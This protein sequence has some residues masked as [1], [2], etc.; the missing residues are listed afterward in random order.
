MPLWKGCMLLWKGYKKH[1][2]PTI[3]VRWNLDWKMHLN[4]SYHRLK[5]YISFSTEKFYL[6]YFKYPEQVMRPEVYYA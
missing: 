4:Y 5:M 6:I 3:F 1:S 2:N